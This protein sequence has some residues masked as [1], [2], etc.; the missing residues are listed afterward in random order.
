M[1]I[2]CVFIK[3]RQVLF[4]AAAVTS[5]FVFLGEARVSTEMKPHETRRRARR[6][7]PTAAALHA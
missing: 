3:V 6:A 4:D 2:E 7:A 1:V 5:C